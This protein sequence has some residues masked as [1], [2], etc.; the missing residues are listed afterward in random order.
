MYPEGSVV[1]IK[2]GYLAGYKWKRSHLYVNGYWLGIYELAIQQCL[3]RELRPGDVFYDVGANAGFFS[4]LGTKSVGEKGHVFAFEPL[5]EN[6]E[7]ARTQFELNKVTNCDLVPMAV[8]D[9]EGEVEFCEGK[10]TSTA[11]LKRPDTESAVS[12]IVLTITLD[13]FAKSRPAPNFIKIDVE[14]AEIMVLEGARGVLHS[15]HAPKV[16]IEFHSDD[17]AN[18]GCYLFEEAEYRLFTLD[19]VSVDSGPP[20]HHTFAIPNRLL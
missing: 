2:S 20:P 17:L 18:K 12:S 5:Q 11:H 10:D 7:T 9:H 16:L 4:L 8:S 13:E 15:A 6:I 19:R 14:G 1:K 3:I